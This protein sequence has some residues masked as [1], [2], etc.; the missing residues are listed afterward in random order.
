MLEVDVAWKLNFRLQTKRSARHMPS[1]TASRQKR[2]PASRK[3][4]ESLIYGLRDSYEQNVKQ[5]F[6][7]GAFG[8]VSV[9]GPEAKVDIRFLDAKR[10]KCSR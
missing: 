7:E 6:R 10:V 2:G 5:P 8:D 3:L 9:S 1:F 4:G